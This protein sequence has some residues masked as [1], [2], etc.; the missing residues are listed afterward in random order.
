MSPVNP[1]FL[2]VSFLELGDNQP[3]YSHDGGETWQRP[4]ELDVGNLISQVNNSFGG[5]FLSTPI[6]PSPVDENIAIASGNGNHVEVTV[7]G[8]ANWTYSG[9]GYTGGRAG[10]ASTSF[11]WDMNDANRFAMFLIDYGVVLTEDGGEIFET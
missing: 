6:A 8:G 7:D 5:E 10:T 4:A 2:F 11:G 9:N 1:D 3:Y